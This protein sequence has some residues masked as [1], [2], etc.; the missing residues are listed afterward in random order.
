MDLVALEY[1]AGK[2]YTYGTYGTSQ[3]MLH[4]EVKQTNKLCIPEQAL[5]LAHESCGSAYR[6]W[7]RTIA[8]AVVKLLRG[9][10]H[11]NAGDCC[12]RGWTRML[13]RCPRCRPSPLRKRREVP[14]ILRLRDGPLLSI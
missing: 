7:S 5:S 9:N 13:P 6:Y 12:S 14:T 8:R 10:L 11:R 1:L 2:V 4:K 3:C